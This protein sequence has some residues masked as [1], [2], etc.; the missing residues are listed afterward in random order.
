MVRFLLLI[1]LCSVSL[2]GQTINGIIDGKITNSNG[3]PLMGVTIFLNKIKKGT[4]TDSD[5][6]YKINDIPTGNYTLEVSSIGFQSQKISISIIA[7]KTVTKNIV[8]KNDILQLG[9]I[10]VAGKTKSAKMEEESFAVKSINVKKLQNKSTDASQ[11]L[12]NVSGIRIRTE[13]GTGSNYNLSLNGLT[14][15]QIRIFIDDTPIDEL[16]KAFQLYNIPVNLIERVDVYK[17]VVPAKLGA[18]ALGGAINIITNQ[19]KSSFLDVSYSFGS[20]NTHKF[21]LNS[22]YRF[23]KSGFTAKLSTVYN[24]SDNDYTMYNIKYFTGTPA[25][26]VRGNVQRFHD[27]FKSIAGSAGIGYTHTKWAD[28]LMLQVNSTST[29]KEIQGLISRPI[30]EAKE[31]EE[32]QIYKLSYKKSKLLNDK[33]DINT[34]LLYNNINSVRIDTTSNRYSWDGSHREVLDGRGEFLSEKTIFRYNQKQFQ[35][36]LNLNYKLNDHHTLNLNHIYTDIQRTGEN[37]YVANRIQAFQAPNKL[38]KNITGIEYSS[39]FLDERLQTRISAKYYHFNM[40]AKEAITFTDQSISINDVETLQKNIGYSLSGR[41]FITP[42]LLVKASYELGY[43]I[44]QPIEIFGDGL[45]ILANPNLKPEKS[46]NLNLGITYDTSIFNTNSL[47][48]EIN[49]FQ[50]NVKN[51]IRLNFL[52]LVNS[53]ENE[54]DILVRGVEWDISFQLK[55]FQL[56]GNLTWQKV[57]NNQDF[58]DGSY[59]EMFYEKEQLPNTPFLF[60]NLNANYF[61]ENLPKSLSANIYYGVNYVEEFFLS[62]EKIARKAPKNIIPRQILHNIGFTLSTKNKKHHLNF[63]IQNLYNQIAF[64]NFNQQKPGRAFYVKYR[65]SLN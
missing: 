20:F 12:N 42:N 13:A 64:D 65:F 25:K 3:E 10:A 11:I 45:G 46:K 51:F 9:E 30:G 55:K 18:D 24:Y 2:K 4:S 27:A 40:L 57:M 5:G 60:G 15:N 17:G 49:L 26:E 22:K 32:N 43:R 44:P 52:G 23:K 14:G 35:Y 56:T 34:Y 7:N 58:P 63:E 21:T 61:M 31:K 47:K 39:Y 50:R 16:G 41:Y 59:Q 54:P 28:E 1:L 48:N 37:E 6:K 29:N 53:Y 19:K 33:L 38:T 36:R 8:L 62:Y